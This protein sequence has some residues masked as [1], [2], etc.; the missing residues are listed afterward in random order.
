[1]L[2]AARY[3]EVWI[4]EVEVGICVA[5]EDR[6]CKSRGSVELGADLFLSENTETWMY[7]KHCKSFRGSCSM[8]ACATEHS[9]PCRRYLA[10]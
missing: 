9:E 8:M 4:R 1:M 5:T 10:Q 3:C 7:E 6:S 2:G